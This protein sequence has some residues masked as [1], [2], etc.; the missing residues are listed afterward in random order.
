M[1]A[2]ELD[3][4]ARS[5]IEA[6]G[7]GEYFLHSLGHGLGLQVHERPKISPLSREELQAGNVVTIEPG[8]YLPTVG[9]VRIEDDVL[10]TD[11]GCKLLSHLN[12]ELQVV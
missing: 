4:I 9:G 10:I 6:A 8:L 7:L 12:R 2:R 5:E 3:R 1:P 11:A